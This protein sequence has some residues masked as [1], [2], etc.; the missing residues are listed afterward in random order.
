MELI[1]YAATG[2]GLLAYLWT[3]PRMV[4]KIGIPAGILWIV[5]FLTLGVWTAVASAALSLLRDVAGAWLGNKLM[6][7][8]TLLLLALVALIALAT[9]A[10]WVSFLPVLVT[11]WKTGAVWLRDF[12]ISFRLAKVGAEMTFVLFG[13][14][15]GAQALIVS[16]SIVI[17]VNLT[18]AGRIW[19]RGRMM[20]EGAAPT[21]SAT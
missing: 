4:L 12:P 20:S 9:N 15:T 13:A 18:T 8:A 17:A 5:Y 11:A 1:G 16:A 3:D 10:G 21:T 6:R 19:W 14:L 7:K 2:I